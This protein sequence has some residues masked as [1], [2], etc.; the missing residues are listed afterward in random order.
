MKKLVTTLA[1][2]LMTSTLFA[3]VLQSKQTGET[4]EFRLNKQTQTLQ[5]ISL[6]PL[7][8]NKTIH[9]TKIEK[10]DYVDIRLFAGTQ[11][12]GDWYEDSDGFAMLPWIFSAG[13]IPAAMV[14]YDVI[15][16]PIKAPIK[17]IKQSNR[18]KDYAKLMKA[19]S[20]DEV[21][22]VSHERLE[23]ISGLLY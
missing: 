14:L 7:V 9:L 6:T 8:K 13:T 21:V 2:T 10:A 12:I 19:I 1:L 3:G 23:R 16:L 20:T 5:I 11:A 15:A 18:K 4:I 17:L 22:F